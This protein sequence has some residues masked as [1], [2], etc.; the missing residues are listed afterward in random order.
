MSMIVIAFFGVLVLGAV[1]G[2]GVGLAM[3]LGTNNRWEG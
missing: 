1:I 2:I 3:I